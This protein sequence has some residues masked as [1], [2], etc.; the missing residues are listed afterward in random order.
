[1]NPLDSFSEVWLVDL[2]FR[3]LDGERPEPICLVAREFR[4]GRVI[5]LWQDELQRLR[6]PPYGVGADSIF[7]AYYASA[8]LGC[9]LALG[10]AMPARI[11]D[12]YAEFR[13]LTSGLPTT[14]GNGLLGAL[15]HYGLPSIDSIKKD[16]MRE[17]ALRGGP[18]TPDEQRALLA[19]CQSDVDALAKLLPVM[20]PRIDLPR[21]LLRGRY[22]SAAARME[23]TVVH[24]LRSWLPPPQ[25]WAAG[26]TSRSRACDF[27]SGR[28]RG[29]G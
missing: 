11:L 8:E 24:H 2:E 22:M 18:Y 17:L 21:A 12:L 16:A 19:Y 29:C 27:P 1:M 14:C 13:C 3:A 6:R 23:W 26:S 5:R 20:I 7:V 15:A 4:S 9:H 25:E 28:A 10:W